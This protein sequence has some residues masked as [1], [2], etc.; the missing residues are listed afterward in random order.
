MIMNYSMDIMTYILNDQ[1]Y[2]NSVFLLATNPT[3]SL[4]ECANAIQ[5]VYDIVYQIKTYHQYL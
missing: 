3:S 5:F 4:Q 1:E 2:L